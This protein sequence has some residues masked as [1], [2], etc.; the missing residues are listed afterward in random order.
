MHNILIMPNTTPIETPKIWGNFPR[1]WERWSRAVFYKVVPQFR[2]R[3]GHQ[4]ID[5]LGEG[6]IFIYI[7]VHRLWKQFISKEINRAEQKYMNI[8]PLSPD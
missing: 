3:Q 2:L 8:Y 4:K 1:L 5:N 7:H 6:H